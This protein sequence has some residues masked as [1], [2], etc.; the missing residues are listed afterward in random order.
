MARG[1]SRAMSEALNA[2]VAQASE[3]GKPKNLD[4]LDKELM[5]LNDGK[6]TFAQVRK[7]VF[8][9]LDDLKPRLKREKRAEHKYEIAMRDWKDAVREA[10]EKGLPI[11]PEP[12]NPGKKESPISSE[13]SEVLS[14][15]V[16]EFQRYQGNGERNKQTLVDRFKE[17]PKAIQLVLSGKPGIIPKLY[18]GDE[19]KI[20]PQDNETVASFATTPRNVGF[21]G[22][23]VYR[24]T[25]IASYEGI[26]DTL[27][28][29]DFFGTDMH[30]SRR[31]PA[32]I[33]AKLSSKY[34]DYD[35]TVGSD[36]DERVVYGIKWK[37]NV[38]DEEWMEKSGRRSDTFKTK[39]YEKNPE[40]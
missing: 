17:L 21:W 39:Y 31:R 16:Y 34:G 25:D 9:L 23:F 7:R 14:E 36:E 38:G 2:P 27:K 26:I 4:E 20:T 18:R 24:G 13:L 3:Q 5:S 6:P 1:G 33:A 30:D 29:S 12:V 19:A 32:D 28:V 10:K 11:P 15:F 8:Q 37:K 35:H 40:D 22:S